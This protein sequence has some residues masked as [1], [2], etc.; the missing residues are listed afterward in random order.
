MSQILHLSPT[1]NR[2]MIKAKG[3]YVRSCVTFKKPPKYLFL[4]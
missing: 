2:R 3:F 1:P 4:I